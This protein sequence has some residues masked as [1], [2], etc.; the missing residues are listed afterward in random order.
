MR[1]KKMTAFD[2]STEEVYLSEEKASWCCVRENIGCT[3]TTTNEPQTRACA[4]TCPAEYDPVCGLADGRT[5]ENACMAECNGVTDVGAGE[6]TDS[7]DGGCLCS[8]EWEPVCDRST[9]DT[10]P[11]SCIAACNGIVGFVQGP[12]RV[13][14]ETE[15]DPDGDDDDDTLTLEAL[16]PIFEPST[17]IPTTTSTETTTLSGTKKSID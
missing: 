5:Y 6:C 8:D 16:P 10:V 14:T 15:T 3:V 17:P 4:H 1:V 12:C 7:P 9:G 2:C 11:N 13:E